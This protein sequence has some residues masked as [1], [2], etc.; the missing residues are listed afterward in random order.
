MNRIIYLIQFVLDT[1]QKRFVVVV[2][3]Q[4]AGA[5]D[6]KIAKAKWSKFVD[7]INLEHLSDEQIKILIYNLDDRKQWAALHYAVDANNIHVFSRLTAPKNPYQ[8]GIYSSFCF[9]IQSAFVC[10]DIHINGGNGENVL[11]IAARSDHVWKNVSFIVIEKVHLLNIMRLFV[12][13]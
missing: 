2:F 3:F 9:I 4:A 5:S 11:H 1:K 6:T 8:C 7:Q 13:V 10:L 12:V